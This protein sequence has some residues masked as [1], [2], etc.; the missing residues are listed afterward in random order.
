MSKILFVAI[1]IVCC[2]VSFY[3]GKLYGQKKADAGGDRL[4]ILDE[5]MVVLAENQQSLG[6]IPAGT[7]LYGVNDPFGDRTSLYKL[8]LQTD[9]NDEDPI[10]SY[11]KKSAHRFELEI[12]PLKSKQWLRSQDGRGM[13]NQEGTASDTGQFKS[14]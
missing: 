3:F 5:E 2:S 14:H 11:E 10:R 8:Y 12:Y 9:V 6:T 7:T 13:G 1:F 4:V